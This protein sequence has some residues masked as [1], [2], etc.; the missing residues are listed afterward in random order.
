MKTAYD[1]LYLDTLDY[2]S[3][4][5]GTYALGQGFLARIHTES[6]ELCICKLL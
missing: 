5:F 4:P 6:E 2:F 3:L 1:L